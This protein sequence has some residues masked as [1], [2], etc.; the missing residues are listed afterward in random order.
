MSQG[1]VGVNDVSN[2][3]VQF[4]PDPIW[5][6]VA[7]GGSATGITSD[8]GV[9]AAV[10]GE[11]LCKL[12]L[13][14]FYPDAGNCTMSCGFT[15][16]TF[17]D[18]IIGTINAEIN[19]RHPFFGTMSQ[20]SG[21]ITLHPAGAGGPTFGTTTKSVDRDVLIA[22]YGTDRE[23]M[24]GLQWSVQVRIPGIIFPIPGQFDCVVH[25]VVIEIPDGVDPIT[26]AADIELTGSGGIELGGEADIEV[27]PMVVITGSGGFELGNGGLDT[28]TV[29]SA[30]SSGIYTLIAGQR[31]D[32]VYTRNVNPDDTAQV[33]IPDPFFKTGFIGG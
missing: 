14:D 8:D 29:L 32:V 23:T 17:G 19:V 11:Y 4:I 1:L 9:S 18:P 7:P 22:A 3:V 28:P 13:P 2:T 31:Y 30:D 25:D 10:T 20:L 21:G 6:A 5:P 15:A 26:P 16:G 27:S 24:F 12:E 33:Q